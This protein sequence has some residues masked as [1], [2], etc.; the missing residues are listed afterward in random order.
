MKAT[1][2]ILFIS[3]ISLSH[4]Q[5]PIFKEYVGQDHRSISEFEAFSDYKS[6]GGMMISLDSLTDNFGFSHYGNEKGQIIVFE[7]VRTVNGKG[8]Y[9]FIDGIFLNDLATNQSLMYGQCRLNGDANSFI[10]VVHEDQT[11]EEEFFANIIRAW[12]AN[13]KNNSFEEIDTKGIDC[14]NEGYGCMH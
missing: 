14:Y 1:L 2:T 7:I 6:F 12:R 11:G 8:V 9:T 3:A 5:N 13:P 10:V 4:A